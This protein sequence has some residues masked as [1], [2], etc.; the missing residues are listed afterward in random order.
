MATAKKVNKL[1]KDL[2]EINQLNEELIALDE[3]TSSS[4]RE[5]SKYYDQTKEKSKQIEDIYD[6]AS[7]ALKKF[8][9]DKISVECMQEMFNKINFESIES[10][11]YFKAKIIELYVLIY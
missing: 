8:N 4:L 7:V 10:V 3:Q 1:K 6:S 11:Q 9:N 5:I 2:K